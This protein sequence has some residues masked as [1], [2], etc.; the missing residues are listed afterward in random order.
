MTK[1]FKKKGWLNA[2]GKLRD[3]LPE[4][5]QARAPRDAALA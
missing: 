2:A 1:E 4:L 3:D 5:Q